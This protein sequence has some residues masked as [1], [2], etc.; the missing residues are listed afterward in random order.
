MKDNEKKPS[1]PSAFP[2]PNDSETT[3]GCDGM[4]LMTYSAIHLKQPISEFDW[5]NEAIIKAKKD[6]F[7]NSAMQGL[8]T[9]EQNFDY[10]R[11][12]TPLAIA[13]DSYLIADAMLKQR[14][15]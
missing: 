6:Y 1:N 12:Q 3:F 2:L 5:L 14:E 7:A 13:R 10:L 9:N 15:L 8:I 11:E 4:S